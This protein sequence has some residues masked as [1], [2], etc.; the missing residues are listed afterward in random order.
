MCIKADRH[1]YKF[2]QPWGGNN[3]AIPGDMGLTTC[4]SW[5]VKLAVIPTIRICQW[6]LSETL[7]NYY[8]KEMDYNLYERGENKICD[9]KPLKILRKQLEKFLVMISYDPRCDRGTT[10]S[11]IE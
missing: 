6:I 10:L 1:F 5:P 4:T 11:L 8:S 7:K 2:H 3:V 9:R